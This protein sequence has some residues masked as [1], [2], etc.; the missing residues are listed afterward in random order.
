MTIPESPTPDPSNTAP[1][2]RSKPPVLRACQCSIWTTPTPRPSQIGHQFLLPQVPP[3]PLRVQGRRAAREGPQPLVA[4]L[5]RRALSIAQEP[6][7]TPEPAMVSQLSPERLSQIRWHRWLQLLIHILAVV[8]S[9]SSQQ[10]ALA[11]LRM[12]TINVLDNDESTMPSGPPLSLSKSTRLTNMFP[13]SIC[14]HPIIYDQMQVRMVGA[15][16]CIRWET[17]LMCG[18]RWQL[19]AGRTSAAETPRLAPLPK[20]RI[21]ITNRPASSAATTLSAPR[22]TTSGSS[23]TTSPLTLAT[24]RTA[25][26]ASWIPSTDGSIVAGYMSR[27]DSLTSALESAA[28]GRPQPAADDR[29]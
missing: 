23:G 28:G 26:A 10:Q 2:H 19:L 5:F 8:Q 15:G 21:N 24:T 25:P 12:T 11:C 3:Q 20:T 7:P 16:G 17:C 6:D 1:L 13:P 29:R 18:C 22:P 14:P 27:P 9:A 4:R